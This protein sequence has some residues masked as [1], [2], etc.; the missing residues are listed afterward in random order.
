VETKAQAIER[1]R[2][3]PRMPASF[4]PPTLSKNRVGGLIELCEEYITPEMIGRYNGVSTEVFALFAAS[5]FSYDNQRIRKEA[6]DRLH[7][8]DNVFC[9]QCGTF[10][11]GNDFVHG[12]IFD[13]V[14]LDNVHRND[15][16]RREIETWK[17]RTAIT[18]L[19][20]FHGSRF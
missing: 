8:Y 17:P 3:T 16:V 13:L 19:M 4:S 14:Y 5:V 10:E 6:Y 7:I 12:R 9:R 20:I 15:W 1:L 2:E 18:S 11:A